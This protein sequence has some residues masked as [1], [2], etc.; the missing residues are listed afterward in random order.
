MNWKAIRAIRAM[1]V[2]LVLASGLWLASSI[3]AG[4]ETVPWQQPPG[5]QPCNGG[6]SCDGG[7]CCNGGSC[8]E[9]ADGPCCDEGPACPGVTWPAF[10][11]QDDWVR[12]DALLWWSKGASIP[13]LLTTGTGTNAGILGDP[14]TSVLFGGQEVNGGFRPGGRVSFGTWLDCEDN[15]GLEMSYL[16]LGQSQDHFNATANQS[17][18][19]RAP[20]STSAR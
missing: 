17:P 3:M 20:F 1:G 15:I 18:I 12:L 7:Q 8:G 2:G 14:N 19:L 13:P 4:E 16:T 9:C 11:P 10:M 5:G 6:P